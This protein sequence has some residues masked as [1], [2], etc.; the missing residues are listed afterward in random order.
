MFNSRVSFHISQAAI[1]NNGGDVHHLERL[2]AGLS[3]LGIEARINDP[4]AFQIDRPNTVFVLFNISDRYWMAETIKKIRSECS[5][6]KILV[7]P[8]FIPSGF[9]FA[10]LIPKVV[11]RESPLFHSGLAVRG[12]LRSRGKIDLLALARSL[13][14]SSFCAVLDQVDLFLPNSESEKGAIEQVFSIPSHRVVVVTNGFDVG[15]VGLEVPSIPYKDFIF[16]A[17]RI[18]ALKNQ[19]TLLK[20]AQQLDVP[21]ILAGSVSRG[22]LKY[23]KQC[24]PYLSDRRIWL[25]AVSRDEISALHSAAAVHCLPSLFETF[26]LSTAEALYFGSPAVVGDVGYLRSVYGDKVHYCDPR[27]VRSVAVALEG[28]LSRNLAPLTKW[29]SWKDAAREFAVQISK[30]I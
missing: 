16:C 29:P 27:S 7:V 22:A 2:A 19:L 4:Y 25:G 9:F 21:V 18:E 17:A 23:F 10:K 13:S 28:A 20:A 8:I 3:S 1:D 30:L 12:L 14:F 24:V 5:S 15:K 11:E 6:A 26:S